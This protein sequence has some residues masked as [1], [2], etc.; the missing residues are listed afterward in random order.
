[1]VKLRALLVVATAAAALAAPALSS[2]GSA[3]WFYSPDGVE[4][5]L[6]LNRSGLHRPTYA[7]CLAYQPGRPTRTAI[8]VTMNAS[9]KLTIC[10]GCMSNQPDNAQ[11]LAVGRSIAL[12]PFRCTSLHVG[13]RC[14]VTKL[15]HGFKLSTRGLTRI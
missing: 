13:V 15:G 3:R 14:V 9:G 12:G 10:H 2:G 4:C 6:G 5:E 7:F 11:R 8:A 1:V